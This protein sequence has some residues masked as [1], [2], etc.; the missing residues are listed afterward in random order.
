LTINFSENDLKQVGNFWGKAPDHK[1]SIDLYSFIPIRRYFQKL[2]T[3]TENENPTD[4]WLEK[5]FKN[6]YL[7]DKAPVDL[8]LS[9]CCGHGSRDRRLNKL[10]IFKEC[11]G[12]DVS[13]AAIESAKQQSKLAGMDNI[14]YKTAD[15]NNCSLGF[16]LYDFIYIAGGAHHIANLEHLFNQVYLSL[17]KGG[18]LLCDEYVGPN[19]SDLS[20]RHREIINSV[21]HL[22]P[23]RL[24]NFSEKNFIPP[25]LKYNKIKLLLYIL[26][27]FRDLDIASVLEK[28]NISQN[29]IVALLIL[30]NK[31]IFNYFPTKKEFKYGQV[32]D[33]SPENIKKG[34]PS[35]GIRASEIIPV[36]QNVFSDV[37][38]YPYNGSIVAYALDNK[39]ITKFDPS[40]PEDLNLLN[41]I[42]KIENYYYEIGDIPSI[43]AAIIAKK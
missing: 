13:I 20:F 37:T 31:I 2:V 17:K 4:D 12:M 33:I 39:F 27:N 7:S 36:M 21:I 1:S 30:I 22:I 8:C 35:E 14:H 11:I 26:F 38:I 41:L 6:K 43:H 23:N 42:L 34:D 25:D 16:E 3:G 10:G 28:Y 29:K 24:K 19:Y 9:L 40:N 15:L 18:V 5:W 32:F